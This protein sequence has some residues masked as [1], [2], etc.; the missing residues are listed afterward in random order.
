M[1]FPFGTATIQR[2]IQIAK[3]LIQ[4]DFRVIVINK[5]SAHSKSI[6]KREKILF[7][8]LHEGVEY[9][10]SSLITYKPTNFFLRNAFKF[11]GIINEFFIIL[12]YRLFK[13]AKYLLYRA[14]E[15]GSSKYYYFISKMFK[16]KIVYDY[17]EFYDSLGNRNKKN[18]KDLDKSF[19][20]EFHKYT[21]KVI[22]ISDFLENHVKNIAPAKPIIKIPPTID[23]SY[24]DSITN[25]IKGN[26]FF[27]FCGSAN[28]EDIIM[29]IIKAF[30]KSNAIP[31]NYELKLIING[32]P[33][34]LDQLDQYIKKIKLEKNIEIMSGLSY[35]DL[36]SYYKS[37][38]ALLIPIGSSIQD[39]ARFPFK[40]CEYTASKRPI[41]TSNSGA[42]MEFFEH[43]VN[44]YIA[45][46]D[47]I[48]DF[49]A[50]LNSV[51]EKPK[52]ADE[53]GLNGY[54]LGKKIFNFQTYS[55][56][57]NLFITNEN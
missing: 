20:Y 38:K 26:P 52:Y 39:Q 42:V 34:Q 3:S 56:N 15:L 12:Y 19:D 36:V 44:A 17:V 29:Y 28:Y 57:L 8:G 32:S 46:T 13:N 18:L 1:G 37:A 22:V 16:L 27:L 5:R 40:I 24:F 9:I 30:I 54:K 11:I 10:Y 47:I 51:I 25:K 23:F 33:N 7:H 6:S 49:A 53:I 48:E 31:N 41:I 14:N 43:N 50:N 4:A 21:D 45:K 2:Q 55:K 35:F